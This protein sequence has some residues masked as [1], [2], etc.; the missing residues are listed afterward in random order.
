VA[1]L[2]AFIIAFLELLH[3]VWTTPAPRADSRSK[4][5]WA[6]CGFAAKRSADHHQPISTHSQT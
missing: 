5:K 4:I 2:V 1:L 6:L 3:G